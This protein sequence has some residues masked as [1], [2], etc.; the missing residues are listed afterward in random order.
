MLLIIVLFSILHG[1][2]LTTADLSTNQTRV[3]LDTLP[4]V[5]NQTSKVYVVKLDDE[6]DIR[7]FKNHDKQSIETRYLFKQNIHKQVECFVEE[8]RRINL[9]SDFYNPF[10]EGL[11][12]RHIRSS[13][14]GIYISTE[15]RTSQS[16]ALILI[17]TFK[18][19]IWLN[20]TKIYNLNHQNPIKNGSILSVAFETNVYFHSNSDLPN[21]NEKI[22]QIIEQVHIS[23]NTTNQK[24]FIMK[25]LECQ[26]HEHI[27]NDALRL[28]IL[29]CIT[30]VT[31]ICPL[32]T[33]SSC[34]IDNKQLSNIQLNIDSK[35]IPFN[36]TL[37][38]QIDV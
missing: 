34:W 26:R 29:P 11:Y 30:D 38:I 21:L 35:F 12:A 1:L 3:W 17:D 23:I 13:Q 8:N 20:K 7:L 31:F 24:F 36:Q 28:V 14:A 37:T 27:V 33:G 16:L 6:I 25:N 22:N 10:Y 4:R 18:P 19:L 32:Q 5:R 2:C 9:L 15:N